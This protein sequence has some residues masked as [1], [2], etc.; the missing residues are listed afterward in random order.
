M[1]SIVITAYNV[2]EYIEQAIMSVLEQTHSNI[3][4]IIVEDCS[5]DNTLDIIETIKAHDKRV[6]LLRNEQNIGAGASRR[7]GIEAATGDYILLLDGDDWIEKDFIESLYRCAVENDADIVSG[8]IKVIYPDGSCEAGS[9]GNCITEGSDKI[10]RFWGEKIVFMNNKL[11]RRKLHETIPYCTR[12][13]IEDTPTIIKQLYLANKVAYTDNMGYNYRMRHDSLTHKATKF[14]YALF[15]AIC[16]EELISFFE[17]HDKEYL[18][19]IPL[20]HSYASL[21]SHIIGMSPQKET[22]QEYTDEW[23]EFTTALLKRM[24]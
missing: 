17:E 20:G 10:E 13:F 12:R 2:G 11:I 23:I 4:C 21:V 1:V 18:K 22:I 5:K 9:Y 7:R 15:R 16:A 8:G 24:A 6:R 19:R 14:K 3:E